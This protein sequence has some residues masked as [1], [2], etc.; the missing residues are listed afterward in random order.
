M[1]ESK[2]SLYARIWCDRAST[3]GERVDAFAHQLIDDPLPSTVLDGCRG[4]FES[5]ARHEVYPAA[6]KVWQDEGPKALRSWCVKRLSSMGGSTST[7]PTAN[8]MAHY[9]LVEVAR[10]LADITAVLE[11][12][13]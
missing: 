3:S 10:V 4:V 5:A 8:L 9:R 13:P 12:T 2:F 7:D 1:A 11:P 6:L